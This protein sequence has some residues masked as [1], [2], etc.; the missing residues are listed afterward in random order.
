MMNWWADAEEDE[1]EE[2][3]SPLTLG[4]PRMSQRLAVLLDRVYSPSLAIGPRGGHF[5]SDPKNFY[6]RDRRQ[7]EAASDPARYANQVLWPVAGAG[8][9]RLGGITESTLQMMV[10]RPSPEQGPRQRAGDSA[11]AQRLQRMAGAAGHLVTPSFDADQRVARKRVD[12]NELDADVRLETL[13]ET[14]VGAAVVR[15]VFTQRTP[16]L[17]LVT[18]WDVARYSPTRALGYTDE[19]DNPSPS[20]AS[21][22]RVSALDEDELSRAYQTTESVPPSSRE[23]SPL[24]YY[25]PYSPSEAAST[26]EPEGDGEGLIDQLRNW[27]GRL[28]LRG[29]PSLPPRPR[30]R[31]RRTSVGTGIYDYPYDPNVSTYGGRRQSTR[32]KETAMGAARLRALLTPRPPRRVKDGPLPPPADEVLVHETYMEAIGGKTLG[33]LLHRMQDEGSRVLDR[34]LAQSLFMVVQSLRAAFV[35]QGFVHHDLHLG[36]IMYDAFPTTLPNARRYLYLDRPAT[37]RVFPTALTGSPVPPGAP[38]P[39]PASYKRPAL[40]EARL[41]HYVVGAPLYLVKI[42]DYGRA[43]ILVSNATHQYPQRGDDVQG[44]G[45]EYDSLGIDGL[46]PDPHFDLRVLAWHL[47]TRGLYATY[48][49]DLAVENDLTN[50]VH[51]ALGGAVLP[52]RLGAERLGRLL[53]LDISRTRTDAFTSPA[54]KVEARRL[55]HDGFLPDLRA[56]LRATGL[57]PEDDGRP[58][59]PAAQLAPRWTGAYRLRFLQLVAR[60]MGRTPDQTAPLERSRKVLARVVASVVVYRNYTTHALRTDLDNVPSDYVMDGM[61]A[62]NALHHPLFDTFAV[63]SESEAR[64]LREEAV[65][66]GGQTVLAALPPVAPQTVGP[67]PTR[68][69][70]PDSETDLDRANPPIRSPFARRPSPSTMADPTSPTADLSPLRRYATDEERLE[71]QRALRARLPIR[72]DVCDGHR[73][74]FLCGGCRQRRYCSEQCQQDDWECNHYFQCA[75]MAEPAT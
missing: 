59:L 33:N 9:R 11:Y 75:V 46:H 40:T 48:W 29:S 65:A 12:L 17:T 67:S 2:S 47:L 53:A 35:D 51:T 26:E 62:L 73:A 8:E 38:D 61:S 15:L 36:N 72:C 42:I 50:F 55:L 66:P 54:D 7:L 10:P 4:P 44:L 32:T 24:S 18:D 22:R 63:T 37:P 14:L 3:A 45:R 34:V 5:A 6:P 20:A 25:T 56:L 43:R 23:S 60:Y 30:E 64:Q 68:A 49:Q 74:R 13:N 28:R 57:R 69:T 19:T 58:P 1:E 16:H 70:V 39:L 52:Y 21:R 31:L 41:Q 27:Y 71:A